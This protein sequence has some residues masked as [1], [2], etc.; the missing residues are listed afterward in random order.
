MLCG[1]DSGLIVYFK[2]I[3]ML[4]S[5]NLTHK[6][7]SHL[8]HVFTWTWSGLIFRHIF[9]KTRKFQPSNDL[10]PTK[11]IHIHTQIHKH[12]HKNTSPKH[13][14]SPHE[15]RAYEMSKADNS[16]TVTH[17][18][19]TRTTR[20]NDDI[21]PL[22][23]CRHSLIT[24]HPRHN[25]PSSPLWSYVIWWQWYKLVEHVLVFSWVSTAPGLTQEY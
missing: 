6:S 9:L 19:K 7:Y 23:T 10:K 21:Y 25:V 20:W 5:K 22:A 14:P 16:Q 13:P 2:I 15:F 24:N 12:I 3:I 17:T 4:T 11:K 8:S 18:H 1:W